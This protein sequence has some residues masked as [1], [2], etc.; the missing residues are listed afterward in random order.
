MAIEQNGVVL[1]RELD[2]QSFVF[3]ESSKKIK[4]ALGVK[5]GNLEGTNLELTL[6]NGEKVSIDLASLIPASK[7]DTF[8][9]S[10]TLEGDKLK[11]TTG[12][13]DATDGDQTIEVPVGD[14]LKSTTGNGLEG[15]GS[16]G[17]KLAIKI[18]PASHEALT[19]GPDGIKLDATKIKPEAPVEIKSAFGDV[20]ACAFECATVLAAVRETE[21]PSDILQ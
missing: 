21:S 17:A 1:A 10:V 6:E 15:D 7:M 12:A 3:D 2:T 14:L 5:A 11:F 13:T 4:V 8:L 16:T 9:K 18:D 20:V 19:V